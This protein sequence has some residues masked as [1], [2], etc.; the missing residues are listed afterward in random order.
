MCIHYR[1][2]NGCLW[3][4][5]VGR[6][7][8][9]K[10][11][12]LHTDEGHCYCCAECVDRRNRATSAFVEQMQGKGFEDGEYLL[13]K[14]LYNDGGYPALVPRYIDEEHVVYDLVE[15][16]ERIILPS[17]IGLPATP[18]ATPWIL[19]SNIADVIDVSDGF[20]WFGHVGGSQPEEMSETKT[21]DGDGFPT[22]SNIIRQKEQ[23]RSSEPGRVDLGPAVQKVIREYDGQM[24]ETWEPIPA[25]TLLVRIAK[26]RLRLRYDRHAH[27]EWLGG[28][29]RQTSDLVY[30]KTINIGD[31]VDL[32]NADLNERI[33]SDL[34]D[35]WNKKV[36]LPQDPVY[37]RMNRKAN[38]APDAEKNALVEF[39][40]EDVE[41]PVDLEEIAGLLNVYFHGASPEDVREDSE[42]AWLYQAALD[43]KTL[44]ELS[45]TQQHQLRRR[46][47]SLE[48]IVEGKCPTGTCPD[49]LCTTNLPLADRREIHA[50]RL[51]VAEGKTYKKYIG[52]WYCVVRLD[53]DRIKWLPDI[54]QF[55]G[56][57]E[58]ERLWAAFQALIAKEMDAAEKQAR[59]VGEDPEK[60]RQAR[61]DAFSNTRLSQSPK[62]IQLNKLK[63]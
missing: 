15:N 48:A 12:Y 63:R 39:W 31:S 17:S 32:Y 35:H 43:P 1:P 14:R 21:N 8:S 55:P 26:E 51:N 11:E 54:S 22:E 41:K 20:D 3:C 56:E 29:N 6:P 47:E 23:D 2:E 40:I 60:A 24:F 25:N 46:K 42:A 5:Q 58:A 18:W 33:P 4:K 62:A 9:T 59:R 44:N 28:E 52:R 38:P 16:L 34:K 10:P 37:I 7:D 13:P 57:T 19:Y 49:N 50:L 36:E 30:W 53:R 27:E 61:K 45:E